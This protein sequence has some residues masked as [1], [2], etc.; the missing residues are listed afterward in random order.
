MGLLLIQKSRVS[1]SLI[2]GK[3][4]KFLSGTPRPYRS[5]LGKWSQSSGV[6]GLSCQV[7]NCVQGWTDTSVPSMELLLQEMKMGLQ[8][9]LSPICHPILV[10]NKRKRSQERLQG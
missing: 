10:L 8:L 2:I 4:R 7:V 3:D 6:V 5:L 9:N 1:G